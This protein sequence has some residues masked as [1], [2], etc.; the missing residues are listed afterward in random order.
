MLTPWSGDTFWR[1]LGEAGLARYQ[2]LV[3]AA[4]HAL[5]LKLPGHH[6][7]GRFTSTFLMERVA[8]CVGGTD[9]LVAVLAHDVT[10]GYGYLRIGEVLVGADRDPEAME[11]LQ[12]GLAEFPAD[13]R[14][15][16]LAAGCHL[17]A[18]HTDEALALLWANF[19]ADPSLSTYQ[20]LSAA[21]GPAW[22]SWRA[23]A[24]G[25]LRSQPRA[26]DA[27]AG[28]EFMAP[29]GHSTLVVV[30]LWDGEPDAAWA[31]AKS[32]GCRPRLWLTVARERAKTHPAD[33]IPILQRAAEQ[34]ID[35]KQRAAYRDA[36][37]LLNEAHSLALRCGNAEGAIR[38][39]LGALLL[40]LAVGAA[41]IAVGLVLVFSGDQQGD[42]A[43]GSFKLAHFV[44]M[45]G[46]AILPGLAWLALR[47]DWTQR[48]R[49]QV[50]ALGTTGYLLAAATVVVALAP[51]ETAPPL[52]LA[53]WIVAAAGTVALLVAG[54]LVLGGVTAS[55][56]EP[57]AAHSRP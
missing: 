10:S 3:E 24:L 43:G 42:Y 35:H 13:R 44:A 41:M 50:V 17:R 32:G 34:A 22:P 54:G 27:F 1:V 38:I 12:R 7:S 52:S 57:E 21:A 28:R 29:A 6:D 39:G 40:A 26:A 2:E 37:R 46:I 48:A 51:A 31:A 30:L 11:W 15:R 5:P 18:G 45:H 9:A 4:W 49:G 20:Q 23:K 25:L 16:D 53:A 19:T 8:E 55:R 56:T 14:L 36:A 33:A 47:T